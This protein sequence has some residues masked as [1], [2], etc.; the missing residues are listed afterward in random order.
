MFITLTTDFAKQSPAVGMMEAAIAEIAPDARVIHYAHGL[1]DYDTTS[2]ARVLETVRFVASSVHV[3]VCDPGVGTA[4]RPL[5]LLTRRGDALV[6]PDN[7]VL[8][9]AAFALGGIG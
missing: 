8:L 4:R 7:G 1:G 6:G 5:A 2:A 9:P 3:C